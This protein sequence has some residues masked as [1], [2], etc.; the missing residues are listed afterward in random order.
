MLFA[1]ALHITMRGGEP[2]PIGDY[3]VVMPAAWMVS[4]VPL[5]PGGWGTRELAFIIGF[6]M[7]GVSRNPAVALS[8]MGGMN[9]LIWSLLG[10]IYVILD[11]GAVAAAA[12]AEEEA[13]ELPPA[14]AFDG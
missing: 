11:R 12:A 14:P 10:G 3:M 6:H 13:D 8:V 5:F 7:V 9:Q 4:A 1:N 2:L